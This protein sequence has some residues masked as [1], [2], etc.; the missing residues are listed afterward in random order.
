[1]ELQTILD[2]VEAT[3][4]SRPLTFTYTDINNGHPL[5]HLISH[6]DNVF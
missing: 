5:L 4:N 2:K 1:M 3:L 6:V